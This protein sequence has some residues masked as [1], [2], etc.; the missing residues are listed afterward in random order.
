MS[1]SS[2]LVYLV[3]LVGVST[4]QC[5]S[6]KCE[7]G[8]GG[9]WKGKCVANNN[10][11]IGFSRCDSLVDNT[12]ISQCDGGETCC[13]DCSKQTRLCRKSFGGSVARNT[14]NPDSIS[15]CCIISPGLY[16]L[17]VGEVRPGSGCSCC[18]YCKRK[19]PC[20]AAHGRCFTDEDPI[21]NRKWCEDNGG[22]IWEKGCYGWG[23]HCCVGFDSP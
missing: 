19:P 10:S 7:T 11:L 2:L 9:G 4:V 18:K 14:K 15:P 6:K 22:R 20:R 13:V 1:T 16:E 12:T 8:R 21:Y 17:K 23:C 3:V 5:Q